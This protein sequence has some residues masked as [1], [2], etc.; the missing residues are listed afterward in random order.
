MSDN[1]LSVDDVDA[2]ISGSGSMASNEFAEHSGAE[3]FLTC[4]PASQQRIIRDKFPTLGE[5]NERFAASLKDRLLTLL[6]KPAEVLVSP[7]QFQA[8][9][10]FQTA[11]QASSVVSKLTIAPLI[12][13]GLVVCEAPL[14]FALVDTLFGGQSQSYPTSARNFS[15]T[16]Q[17]IIQRLTSMLI[18]QYQ[19]SWA[20]IYPLTLSIQD[21]VDDLSSVAIVSATEVIVCNTFTIEIEKLKGSFH[22]CF[23]YTSLAPIRD[24]LLTSAFPKR[25]PIDNDWPEKLS[26]QIEFAEV[27]LI[28]N[29]TQMNSSVRD[30]LALEKGQILQCVIDKNVIATVSD[31]P[32]LNC[33]FGSKKGRIALK[34]NYLVTDPTPFFE[35]V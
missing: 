18:D 25:N 20:S 21:S 5:I 22:I 12:G 10:E 28:A 13:F 16:E 1:S 9:N 6:R 33:R 3:D 30:L 26:Q 11:I 24:V 35:N 32:L 34:V 7:V 17:S 19:Q 23:P 14:V 31:V 29:F 2:L 8:F 27:E 4:D 15:A